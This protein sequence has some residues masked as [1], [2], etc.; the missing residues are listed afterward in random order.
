MTTPART[1]YGLPLAAG[2]R[3]IYFHRS[4]PGWQKPLLIV[5]GLLMLIAVIGLLLLYAGITAAP[6]AYIVTTRRFIV[7]D[8]KTVHALAREE[9]KQV[10]RQQTN[11]IV[12]WFHFNGPRGERVSFQVAD[13]PRGLVAKLDEWLANPA[14][15]DAAPEA[16][17]P[18]SRP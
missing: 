14:S 13:N 6:T 2:E 3:V 4:E 12:K 18:A 1:V 8:G 5:V 7:V 15:M 9:V 10:I 11:S 17:Y 16:D